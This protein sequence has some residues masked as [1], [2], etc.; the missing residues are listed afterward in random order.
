LTNTNN[1]VLNKLYELLILSTM[2]YSAELWL[3]SVVQKKLEI[4]QSINRGFI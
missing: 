2:L 3:L 4:N 1:L